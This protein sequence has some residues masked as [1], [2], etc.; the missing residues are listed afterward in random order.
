MRIVESEKAKV[1]Q[2]E[3]YNFIFNKDTGYFARWGKTKDEDPDMSPIGPEI[4]DLEISS[5]GDCSGKCPF[6]Y[7][8]NGVN[9]DPTYNMT[10]DEFK[11][12]FDKMPKTLTQIAKIEMENG[13]I[14]S[15]HPENRVKLKNGSIKMVKN[16]D[17]N[18]DI[19]GIFRGNELE[20]L[21]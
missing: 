20:F 10:F 9:G 17:K 1:C 4:L 2:S 7:K 8:C 11:T 21:E 18:D 5:G 13:K 12:I 19:I 16:I 14:I 6:C 15:V 3:S